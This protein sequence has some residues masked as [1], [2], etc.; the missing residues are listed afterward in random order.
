MPEDS[1]TGAV[2]YARIDR[3]STGNLRFYIVNLVSLAS[4]MRGKGV[5]LRRPRSVLI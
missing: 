4:T 5:H 3:T 2:Q 1:L